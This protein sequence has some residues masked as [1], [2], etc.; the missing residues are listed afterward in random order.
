M[1]I[2]GKNRTQT[3][4]ILYS[5]WK[6]VIFNLTS[7]DICIEWI[8]SVDIWN[9]HKKP[10]VAFSESDIMANTVAEI[11]LCNLDLRHVRAIRGLNIRILNTSRGY[12]L[13]VNNSKYPNICFLT[14]LTHTWTRRL[15]K[16]VTV[17]SLKNLCMPT[18]LFLKDK[19]TFLNPTTLPFTLFDEIVSLRNKYDHQW[20]IMDLDKTVIRHYQPERSCMMAKFPAKSSAKGFSPYHGKCLSWRKWKVGGPPPHVLYAYIRNYWYSSTT[21]DSS[22]DEG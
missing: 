16:L 22:D 17:P 6:I 9:E 13:R 11:C 21:S 5:I 12:L 8:S 14:V 2:Q 19:D 3:I 20:V 4:E 1:A 18:V 10:G 7:E 15:T